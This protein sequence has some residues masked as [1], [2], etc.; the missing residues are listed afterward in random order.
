MLTLGNAKTTK[1][2][3]GMFSGK[4]ILIFIDGKY[5]TKLGKR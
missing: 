3:R 1:R 5:S 2:T 4:Y